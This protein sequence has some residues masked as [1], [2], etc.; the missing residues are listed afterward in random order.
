MGLLDD[1]L[2][3][4]KGSLS[5]GGVPPEQHATGLAAILEYVNSPQVGGVAGLQKMFQQGGLGNVIS[6]WIG[7]GEC[8]SVAERIT[9]RC[10]PASRAESGYRSHATNGNDG[11]LAS[12]S[13]RQDDPEW[14]SSQRQHLA[15]YAEGPD[16]FCQRLSYCDLA[17]ANGVPRWDA[18]WFC[19]A[20]AFLLGRSSTEPQR[21]SC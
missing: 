3:M 12:A 1:V 17:S 21:V 16:R 6:S 13:S 9:Q 15:E 8:R 10:T 14:R 5:S 2:S 11:Q 20:H 18:S 7:T 4:A 19:A